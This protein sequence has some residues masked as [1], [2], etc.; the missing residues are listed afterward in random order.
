MNN[1][2]KTKPGL[3]CQ[4]GRGVFSGFNFVCKTKFKRHCFRLLGFGGCLVGAAVCFMVAFFTLP[5]LA[6]RCVLFTFP[7]TFHDSDRQIAMLFP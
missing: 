7:Y 6:I 4:D 3:R 2:M 1:L 5:F